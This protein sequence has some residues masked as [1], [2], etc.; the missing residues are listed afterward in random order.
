MRR[1]RSQYAASRNG[2]GTE[3]SCCPLPSRLATR[4]P[5]LE[6]CSCLRPSC[7]TGSHHEGLAGIWCERA[8][9][10]SSLL[11]LLGRPPPDQGHQRRVPARTLSHPRNPRHQPP[12]RRPRRPGRR[13]PRRLR[14]ER[15]RRPVG[16]P[17]RPEL[18]V[19]R[20]RVP[21]PPYYSPRSA[22]VP[23][24]SNGPR[25]HRLRDSAQNR[26]RRHE[27]PGRR[28]R[29]WPVGTCRRRRSGKRK[30]HRRSR[31]WGSV[32]S[33]AE[34]RTRL[35]HCSAAAHSMAAGPDSCS[36]AKLPTLR[37]VV[38]R[39]FLHFCLHCPWAGS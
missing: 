32:K 28:G 5:P 20:Q 15:P 8:K 39:F 9:Q 10:V 18:T 36:C 7:R 30:P 16:F 1:V 26:V 35:P 12:P 38:T 4:R 37:P 23:F 27:Y 33:R 31:Q 19:R 13:R 25:E 21:R 6:L 22:R 29:P 3:C 2:V 34:T 14:H 17:P 11:T 24:G